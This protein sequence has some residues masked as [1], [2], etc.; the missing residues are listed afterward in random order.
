MRT[1]HGLGRSVALTADS[2]L[3]DTQQGQVLLYQPR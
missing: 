3:I 1:L 2:A